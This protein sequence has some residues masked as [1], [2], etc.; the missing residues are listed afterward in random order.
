MIHRVTAGRRSPALIAAVGAAVVLLSACGEGKKGSAVASP[1]TE[2]GL[3][4]EV[5]ATMNPP[6]ATGEASATGQATPAAQFP[7]PSPS[8]QIARVII[9]RAK[10]DAPVQVKGVNANNEMENPDGKDNVAW[11][12]FTAKP[13]FGANAVFSG[14]VDWYTGEAGVF[15]SLRDL[16]N[17]DEIT[18][19]LSDGSSIKYRVVMNQ[20]YKVDSAPVAEIIGPT[21]VEGVTLITC[22][23]VFNRSAQDYSDRRVVRAERIA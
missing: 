13:G 23:G 19:R 15:W 2:R 8:A 17:D 9:P 1:T 16:K 22:E 12:N 4:F 14:H 20:V 21:A 18:V 7:T 10:V 3:V 5:P 6:A 11:Y